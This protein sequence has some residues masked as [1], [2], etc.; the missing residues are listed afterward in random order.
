MKVP[1]IKRS[2]DG[3]LMFEPLRDLAAE[4]RQARRQLQGW[5]EIEPGA[6]DGPAPGPF[7]DPNARIENERPVFDFFAT[8]RKLEQRFQLHA[9]PATRSFVMTDQISGHTTARFY[10]GI[11]EATVMRSALIDYHINKV[12]AEFERKRDGR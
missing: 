3:D 5:K 6:M 11:E 9:E 12:E 4:E 8:R 1:K 7:F 10:E 2:A